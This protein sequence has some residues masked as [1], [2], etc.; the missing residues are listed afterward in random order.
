MVEPSVVMTATRADVVMGVLLAEPEPVWVAFCVAVLSVAELRTLVAEPTSEV[1]LAEAEESTLLQSITP[2][3]MT[4]SA[5]DASP[6]ASR[7]Q[8]RM[9]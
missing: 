6:H 8:S 4:W 1:P 9:P 3:A 2:K 7:A 5:A